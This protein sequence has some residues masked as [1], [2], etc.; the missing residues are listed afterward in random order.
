MA[1]PSPE[2]SQLVAIFV[3]AMSVVTL[4][5]LWNAR[6]RAVYLWCLSGALGSAYIYLSSVA[7]PA[8]LHMSIQGQLLLGLTSTGAA[9]LKVMAIGMLANPQWTARF[10]CKLA[11]LVGAAVVVAPFVLPDRKLVSLAFLLIVV[12]LMVLLVSRAF[13]LGRKLKLANAK[14]FAV[15]IGVQSLMLLSG[16]VMVLLSGDDPLGASAAP[17]TLGSIS[18]TMIVGLLNSALFIALVLDINLIAGARAQRELVRVTA[19]KSRAEE[20]EKMLADMHDGLGS[21]LATARLKVE[22]GEMQQADLADLLRECMADLHLMVDTLRDQGDSL[23]T[24]LVDY[25]FRTERRLAERDIVLDWQVDL[26]HAPPM[27]ANH[28]LQVL[29]IVQ[30]AINN[31]LKHSAAKH[32]RVMARYRKG[33]GYDI[34]VEDDGVGL[35]TD[36]VSGRGLANMRKRA[37][38]IG[39]ELQLGRG[40]GAAG[41]VVNLA[42]PA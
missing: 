21:Q 42:L 7:V 5:I 37:R 9:L 13:Q 3:A 32:I 33:Q 31:A 20:R 11:A 34:R 41:C 15:L 14:A 27:S 8:Q 25:R 2:S 28:L 19:E 16:S 22:R 12:A 26:E 1:F 6:D 36:V 35:S 40:P 23:A 10:C 24:A 17:M 29:R 18:F 38:D 4:G 30:E 39:G